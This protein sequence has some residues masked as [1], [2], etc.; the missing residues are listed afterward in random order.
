MAYHAPNKSTH[1]CSTQHGSG[2]V[3]CAC[4]GWNTTNTTTARDRHGSWDHFG[5]FY[6][7]RKVI[8]RV[9][10]QLMLRSG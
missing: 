1:N 8:F 5:E 4:Q 2:A 3:A 9:G 10:C 7:E 6:H